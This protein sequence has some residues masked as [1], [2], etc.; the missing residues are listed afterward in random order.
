M[1]QSFGSLH[2]HIVFSTK[3]RQPYIED[4]VQSRLFKYVGGIARNL[5]CPLIA[6]GG[7]PDHVHLLCS[8][9]RTVAVADFVRAIKSN[10][11]SWMHGDVGI[12]EFHWQEGYGAFAVSYSNINSVKHYLAN[13]REHHRVKSF[14][15]E[16][17][18]LLRRHELEWDERY[19][20]D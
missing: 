2:C 18:E 8:M 3:N 13:Q 5:K 1:P 17:R 4:D 16:F 12:T 7:M 6:A 14:Q 11:S 9:S 20:W 10:S 15:D 19:V